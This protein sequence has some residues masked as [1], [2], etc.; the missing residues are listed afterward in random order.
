M[1]GDCAIVIVATI[2]FLVTDM[3]FFVI[4]LPVSC[5][6]ECGS[7]ACIL[8]CL[9]VTQQLS[10]GCYQESTKAHSCLLP[11]LS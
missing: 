6:A 7:M 2:D 8:W 1:Y 4:V 11:V 5:N 10:S 3:V 9:S